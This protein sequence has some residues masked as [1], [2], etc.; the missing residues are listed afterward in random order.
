MRKSIMVF[1]ASLVVV[2]LAVASLPK[3]AESCAACMASGNDYQPVVCNSTWHGSSWCW[4]NYGMCAEGGGACEIFIP[5][6]APGRKRVPQPVTRANAKGSIVSASTVEGPPVPEQHDGVLFSPLTIDEAYQ[7]C[8]A[9]PGCNFMAEPAEMARLRRK[10][11]TW[12]TLK[13]VYR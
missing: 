11:T 6:N 4:S 2:I 9:T 12:G 5:D 1:V 7:H 8:M 10:Y 3:S 13:M